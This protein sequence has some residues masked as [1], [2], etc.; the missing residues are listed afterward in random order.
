MLEPFSSLSAGYV[1]PRGLAFVAAAFTFVFLI[2]IFSSGPN[3]PGPPFYAL[4][5]WRL[6]YEDW[7]GT[8]TRTI[9]Q[10]HQKYG[11][12]VRIGPNELSFNSLTALKTIYGAGSGFERTSFYRMFDVYGH[13]NLFTF[14]TPKDHGDRKKLIN[15]AYSKSSIMNYSAAGI[16]G[17]AWEYINLL[18]K[19]P[20]TASE[21]FGSLHYYSLDNITHFLYG[22]EGATSA[23]N[24]VTA[25]RA[26]LDDVLDPS[27]RK[28]SWFAVHFPKYTKW[29]MSRSGLIERLV[30]IAGLL[31]QKK[32]TVYTGIRQH[33]LSSW[34]DFSRLE[35]ERKDAMAVS[36]ILGRLWKHHTS[37]KA[38][39][40]SD[41]EIA[42]EAADHLLAGVDT[43]SDTLMFLIWALSLPENL[44]VQEVLI[45][46]VSALPESALDSR[47]IP[48]AESTDKL[49]YLDA[50]LKETLR[51]YAPLPASE[52]RSLPVDTVI[53]GYQVPANTVVSMSPYTLHRNP[54]VF[55]EPVKFNP[56]RWFG[57]SKEVTEM[58]KW[59]WAFSSGG[60][61]CIGIQWVFSL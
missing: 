1:E 7:K 54:N 3:I 51:L 9:H 5:R 19:E 8:R 25:H 58:K 26:L 53:D 56:D 24:G 4:T 47:G 28:L 61:M 6:A 16:E 46:E 32:P 52:P 29:L 55:V 44:H 35:H 10:L 30:S 2:K 23:M 41:M 20:E 21:I 34:K 57:D 31:P 42:S 45:R 38:R 43:T 48:S 17:N 33:A 40:L 27:R 60:R 39:G 12:V 59:F 36:T 11:S 15:H 13:Q 14:A 22:K 49:A 18:E 50:V 37:Q